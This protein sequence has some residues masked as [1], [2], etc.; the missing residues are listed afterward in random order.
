M[1]SSS[2]IRRPSVDALLQA[3]GHKRNQQQGNPRK[4]QRQW[5]SEAVGQVFP[6]ALRKKDEEPDYT[7]AEEHRL[8][9]EDA[10]VEKR[11]RREESEHLADEFGALEKREDDR[12]RPG[13]NSD[14]SQREAGASRR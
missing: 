6:D 4:Q 7:E 12:L 14:G 5:S 3:H 9:K 10:Q 13:Q 2:L 1:G 11:S 8:S